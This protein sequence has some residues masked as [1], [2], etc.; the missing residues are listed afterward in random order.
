MI[1]FPSTNSNEPKEK[2]IT[3]YN[4]CNIVNRL[5]D[6]EAFIISATT[7]LVDNKPV[8]KAITFNINGY[9]FN[10]DDIW[11]EEPLKTSSDKSKSIYAYITLNTTTSE[12]SPYWDTFA[13]LTLTQKLQELPSGVI[14]LEL[15]DGK[16]VPRDNWVKFNNN[17]IYI[18]DGD[19]DNQ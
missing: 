17:S 9:I 19:L 8:L 7:P 5:V 18:D 13:T 1:V 6:R 2:I 11:G 15:W 4:I 10:T 3:E 14:Y 12:D 16:Q